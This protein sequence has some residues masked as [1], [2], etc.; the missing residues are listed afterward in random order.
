MT[1]SSEFV[2]V[3]GW[4]E[5]FSAH[6]RI[7]DAASLKRKFATQQWSQ[8]EQAAALQS[9]DDTFF[10]EMAEGN[11]RYEQRFGHIF[12]ICAQGKPAPEILAALKERLAN[13]PIYEVQLAAKEQEKITQLRL[14]KLLLH[15][16]TDGAGAADQLR[17]EKLLLY[18]PA[19]GVGATASSKL[20]QA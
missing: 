2:D 16:P 9:S 12:I 7:G 5:A 14:E 15:A 18:A 10:Q 19:D 20:I 13:Q 8:G 3:S 17:L 6:P 4:L 1:H 11:R